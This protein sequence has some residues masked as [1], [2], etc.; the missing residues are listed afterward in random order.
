MIKSHFPNQIVVVGGHHAKVKPYDYL[1]KKYPIDLIITGELENCFHDLLKNDKLHHIKK[2]QETKILDSRRT[3]KLDLLPFP[4]FARYL[5]KYPYKNHFTFELNMSKGC[6]FSCK[7]CR[8]INYDKKIRNFSLEPF[9]M[10]FKRLTKFAKNFTSIPKISFSD[11]TFNSSALSRKVLNYIIDHKMN[12][13]IQFSCQTRIEMVDMNRKL[14]N[15]FKKANMVVGY[16]L[17]SA[18]KQLLL[19]MNKTSQP[20]KYIAKMKKIIQKYKEINEIYCR[21]NIICGFPGEN[22]MSFQRTVNFIEKNAQ[23]DNIQINPTLFSNDPAT[24]VYKSMPTYQKKFGTKFIKEWWKKP[25]D[26]MKSS[27]LPKPSKN[28]YLSELLENY[29][30]KY[31]RILRFFKKSS[32]PTLIHWSKYFK[33]WLEKV[34]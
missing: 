13:E 25:L 18:D 10:R 21:V 8:I 1:D 14:L 11:Q 22:P 3:T 7:F 12:E 23:H 24:H 29:L 33:S 16:G 28:Y 30:E 4:D 6:P 26:P 9:L 32:F 20:S 2:Q 17:E 19:E 15:L 5:E 31:S 34:S 27:V